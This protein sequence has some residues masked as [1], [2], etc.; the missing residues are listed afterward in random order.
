MPCPVLTER[1]VLRIRSAM[2]GTDVAYGA[3][4]RK[5]CYD[6]CA[7]SSEPCGP[8]RGEGGGEG[9]GEE[10]GWSVGPVPVSVNPPSAF[11]STHLVRLSQPT[12]CLSLN[13]PCSSLISQ[14]S[15][16]GPAI[17]MPA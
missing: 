17:K 2:S 4:S 14:S 1:M 13:L 10:E 6:W 5:R 8:G 12:Q 7:G 3:T 9:G 11:Q 16:A 15:E